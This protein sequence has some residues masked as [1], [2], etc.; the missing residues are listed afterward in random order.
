[1]SEGNVKGFLLLYQWANSFLNQDFKREV[2]L[3]AKWSWPCHSNPQT[4]QVTENLLHWEDPSHKKLQPHTA[5]G[6]KSHRPLKSQE[7][8]TKLNRGLVLKDFECLS[9]DY[10]I[11]I[12][13]LK[14]QQD[15]LAYTNTVE[16]PEVKACSQMVSLT[17]PTGSSPVT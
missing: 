11:V 2:S 17:T 1:M 8:F 12:A 4:L 16:Q 10:A 5:E 13:P 6:S 3:S 14:Q 15:T 9:I 7:S